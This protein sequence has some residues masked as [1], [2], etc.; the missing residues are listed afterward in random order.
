MLLLSVRRARFITRKEDRRDAQGPDWYA[1]SRARSESCL[2]P[3]LTLACTLSPR[4]EAVPQNFR[5]N[6]HTLSPPLFAM[7]TVK[8]GK[9]TGIRARA[10]KSLDPRGKY[11]PP[12]HPVSAADSE[13]EIPATTAAPASDLSS[14]TLKDAEWRLNKQDKRAIKHNTLMNKVREGSG[15]QKKK[16]L[17]RR[18]PGKKL[19]GGDLGDLADALPDAGDTGEEQEEEWEGMEEDDEGGA[20]TKKPR[21]KR[22]KVP[23][24]GKM[25]MKSLSMRQGAMK[26]KAEMEGREKERFGR[27]LAKMVEGVGQGMDGDGSGNGQAGRWAALRAFIGGTMQRDEAFGKA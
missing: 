14:H 17:K 24:G 12:L 20:T 21:R 7:A 18:R 16:V 13:P 23:V 27:N 19:V 4:T 5:R 1:L 8:P 10:V 22:R 2:T 11:A 3:T 26:R 25:E 6:H 9:R 15:V